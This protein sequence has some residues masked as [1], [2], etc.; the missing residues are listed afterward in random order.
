MYWYRQELRLYSVV[1]IDTGRRTNFSEA[2]LVNFLHAFFSFDR[3]LRND[4]V[5]IVTLVSGQ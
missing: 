4:Y 5:D 2:L 1:H 3:D